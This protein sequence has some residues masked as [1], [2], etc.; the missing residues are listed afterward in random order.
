MLRKKTINSNN[1]HND[2]NNRGPG[3]PAPGGGTPAS[4]QPI[5]LMIISVV[6]YRCY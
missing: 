2:N 3:A 5:N 1:N 4:E 6:V